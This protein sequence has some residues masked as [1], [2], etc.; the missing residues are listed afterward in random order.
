MT[1]IVSDQIRISNWRKQERKTLRGFFTAILRSG[2]VVHGLALHEQGDVRWIKIPA[3]EWTD[4]HGSIQS[5]PLI[6]F[7]DGAHSDK[8]RDQILAA[9]D[10]HFAEVGK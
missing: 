3:C 9:L 7:V 5:D 4:E 2:M 8:F 1:M 6:G 10:A